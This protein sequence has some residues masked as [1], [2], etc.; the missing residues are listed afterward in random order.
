MTTLPVISMLV[1]ASWIMPVNAHSLLEGNCGD[2]SCKADRE[3]A[4]QKL[5]QTLAVSTHRWGESPGF[6]STKNSVSISRMST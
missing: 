4:E 2:E 1:N 5:E 6:V 3:A